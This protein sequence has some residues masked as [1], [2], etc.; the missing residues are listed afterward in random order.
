M[1]AGDPVEVVATDT[2]KSHSVECVAEFRVLLNG[3]RQE[4]LDLETNNRVCLRVNTEIDV[5]PISAIKRDT[6][7][8]TRLTVEVDEKR[9]RRS[10]VCQ[11]HVI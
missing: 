10:I 4:I 5:V 3:V 8:R 1:T 11:S 7:R 9:V 6:R 2:D